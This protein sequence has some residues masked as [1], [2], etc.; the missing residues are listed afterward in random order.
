MANTA[1]STYLGAVARAIM[2]SSLWSVSQTSEQ[3]SPT[4]SMPKVCGRYVT[5]RSWKKTSTGIAQA[6]GSY[7]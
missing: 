6:T 2:T 1:V 3:T 4:Y 7:Q 5:D